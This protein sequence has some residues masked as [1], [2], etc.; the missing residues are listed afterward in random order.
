MFTTRFNRVLGDQGRWLV[1]VAMKLSLAG[2]LV[3][4]AGA[5]QFYQRIVGLVYLATHE[6]KLD[7]NLGTHI[8]LGV[9]THFRC[10][11]GDALRRVSSLK[12]YA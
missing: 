2:Q 8:D 11:A 9:A 4:P 5:F 7:P 12:W 1:Y 6:C 3:F 10:S